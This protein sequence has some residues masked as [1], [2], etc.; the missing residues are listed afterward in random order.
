MSKKKGLLE[1]LE[2]NRVDTDEEDPL[3]VSTWEAEGPKQSLSS[4]PI[5][6]PS[7]I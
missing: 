2:T 6:R 3:L 5:H 1:L 4:L 7:C